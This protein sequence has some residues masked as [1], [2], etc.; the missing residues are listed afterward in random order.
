[1]THDTTNY[2]SCFCQM[3]NLSETYMANRKKQK[4]LACVGTKSI[5]RIAHK[6]RNIPPPEENDELILPEY[7]RLFEKQKNKKNS[8]WVDDE[9]EKAYEKLLGLHN[10]QLE[11][12]GVDNLSTPEAYTIILGHKSG[13]QRGIG[14]GPPPFTGVN[15]GEKYQCSDIVDENAINARIEAQV[16]QKIVEFSAKKEVKFDKRLRAELDA[17]SREKEVELRKKI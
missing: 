9:A 10:E 6:M 4:M 15:A 13:Y 2:H 17:Y 7:V 16:E 1:M 11:K 8:N 3:K 14:Q 12:H 5:P